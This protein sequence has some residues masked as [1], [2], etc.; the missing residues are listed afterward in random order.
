M[1]YAIIIVA[2]IG[3]AAFLVILR[4]KQAGAAGPAKGKGIIR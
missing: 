3:C 2:I 1:Y 4:K